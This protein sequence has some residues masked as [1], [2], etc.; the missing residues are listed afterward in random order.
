MIAEAIG[1]CGEG[2]FARGWSAYDD[3][4]L[5]PGSFC[6]FGVQGDFMYSLAHWGEDSENVRRTRRSYLKK[7]MGEKILSTPRGLTLDMVTASRIAT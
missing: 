1:V 4:V 5:L 6:S 3:W 2:S 7:G